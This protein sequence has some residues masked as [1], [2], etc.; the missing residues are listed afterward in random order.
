MLASRGI[1]SLLH[2]LESGLKPLPVGLGWEFR[3]RQPSAWA[4]RENRPCCARHAAAV[5]PI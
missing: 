3:V 4:G 1:A 2:R 5:R